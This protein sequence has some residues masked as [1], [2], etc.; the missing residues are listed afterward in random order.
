MFLLLM[1]LLNAAPGL[2]PVYQ[3]NT[4][5]SAEAC[6][7]ERNRIGFDMAEAYPYERDFIIT[8]EPRKE[9]HGQQEDRNTGEVE[10]EGSSQSRASNQGSRET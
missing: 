8:C 10:P 2:E 7:V 6:Q 3:L 4:F 5:D 9:R 1:V